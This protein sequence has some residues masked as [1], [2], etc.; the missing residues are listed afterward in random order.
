MERI[1]TVGIDGSEDA[2]A[3]LAWAALMA[4]AAGDRV[5]PV[6]TWHL[7]IPIVSTAGRRPID[8][9][10]AGLEAAAEVAG[11]H[12]IE[13]SGDLADVI[14]E[15]EIVEGHPAPVLLE[16]GDTGHPLVVGRRG[17]SQL[18]HRLLGSTSSDL[19]LHAACPVVVVP[20]GAAPRAPQ[21]IVVGFDGSE[22]AQA[23]LSWALEV[24]PDTA[25][26]EALVAVDVIPWLKPELV[27]ERHPEAV[28]QARERIGAA[29][30]AVDPEGRA[31]R[32]FVLHGP[33]QALTESFDRADLIVVGPRGVG[34]VART[35]LGSITSWLINDAPCPVAVVH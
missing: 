13:A 28:E 12:A 33:H 25:V 17:V 22:H 24:A 2:Q 23:A 27:M 21:R 29:L 18:R 4:K 16:R 19:V 10:R 20:H 7:S 31:E 35:I 5:Q 6:V 8:V 34:A 9:D 30:D 1:W 26:V 15:P 32:T 14:D 11:A 3:A